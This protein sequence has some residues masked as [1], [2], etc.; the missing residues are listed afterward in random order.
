M[1]EC[2]VPV[3]LMTLDAGVSPAE[4]SKGRSF[5]QRARE[6]WTYEQIP[7]PL[8]KHTPA[9]KATHAP[10]ATLAVVQDHKPVRPQ[11]S[12]RRPSTLHVG[13][14]KTG[15]HIQ[16]WIRK[17]QHAAATAL[18]AKAT[19]TSPDS[20]A[21]GVREEA[22]FLRVVDASKD[23]DARRMPRKLTPRQAM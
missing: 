12:C 18:L 20:A 22:A 2:S 3:R 1:E 6:N 23:F 19:K 5:D 7:E 14:R 17:D 9:P 11:P 13:S 16:Q 15:S 8:P 4:W 21:R 10:A